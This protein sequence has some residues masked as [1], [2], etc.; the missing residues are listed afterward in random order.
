MHRV[1]AVRCS[2]ELTGTIT[3][4]GEVAEWLKALAWKASVRLYR[5]GGSNPP[6]SAKVRS[7]QM[8]YRLYRIHR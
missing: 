1:S 7:G 8:G 2:G 6:L 4:F 5:T 3:K